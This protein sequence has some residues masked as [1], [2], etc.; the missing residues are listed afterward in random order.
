MQKLLIVDDVAEYRDT[1]KAALTRDG[2]EVCTASG[3]RSAAQVLG[4]FTPDVL[5]IDWMLRETLDGVEV[6]SMLRNLVPG[7]KTVL[8]T[9]L[10]A[11][12]LADSVGDGLI[13]AV[14]EKPFT[15]GTLRAAL[16]A[17]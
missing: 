9:G 7:L 12:D 17:L 16:A 15:L 10:P 11:D 13:S 6:A 2:F 8:M 3:S 4:S 14:I 5:V 1:L